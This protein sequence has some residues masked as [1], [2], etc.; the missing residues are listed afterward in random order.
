MIVRVHYTGRLDDGT[1]FD[2]S[3]DR[4]P[5]EFTVGSGQ[6]IAGFDEAVAGLAVGESRTVRIPAAKAYG[7]RRPEMV[8]MV[9]RNRF[10]AGMEF[11]V[12]NKLQLPGD[13]GLLIVTVTDISGE[14]V[15]LDANHELA[16]KDLTFDVE[17][18]EIVSN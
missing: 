15:T 1:V 8:A 12:G 6:V 17:L 2:S 11:A 13:A 10:P 18:V 3:R 5:L 7:H 16:G 4:D 9:D 14:T